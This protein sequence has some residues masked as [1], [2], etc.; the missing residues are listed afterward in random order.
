M[1]RDGGQREQYGG[2]K[3]DAR[4]GLVLDGVDRGGQGLG[5][6]S[7][8]VQGGLQGEGREVGRRR[9]SAGVGEGVGRRG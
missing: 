3:G 1:R 4:P 9:K 7:G 8:G 2:S 6:K 5:D